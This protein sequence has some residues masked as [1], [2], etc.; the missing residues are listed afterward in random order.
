MDDGIGSMDGIDGI[1]SIGGAGS[2]SSC[3]SDG[4]ECCG[5]LAGDNG[6]AGEP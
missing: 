2:I 4:V 6:F 1:G 3:G 5:S